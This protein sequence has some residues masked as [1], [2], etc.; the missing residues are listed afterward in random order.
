[1]NKFKIKPNVRFKL[2]YYGLIAIM[3]MQT[4]GSAFV[5]GRP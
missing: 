1:M 3:L 5:A 2:L 4:V